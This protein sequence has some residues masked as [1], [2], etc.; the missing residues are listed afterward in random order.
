MIHAGV[1]KVWDTFINLTCWADW[2]T[3][4]RDASARK[5]YLEKGETFQCCLR[6]YYFPVHVEPKVIEMVPM[7]KIVWIVDKYGFFSH[8]EYL[9]SKDPGGVKVVSIEKFSGPMMM[10][11]GIFFPEKKVREL[12]RLFLKDLKEHAEF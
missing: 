3:V 10:L 7:E 9:F 1:K 4:L 6:P 8:H 5:S 2:N 11:G 12:N